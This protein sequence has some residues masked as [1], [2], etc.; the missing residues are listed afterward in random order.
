MNLTCT[1]DRCE[2]PVAFVLSGLCR[3]HHEPTDHIGNCEVCE[4]QLIKLAGARGPA[5]KRCDRHKS[6]KKLLCGM[7]NEVN[8]TTHRSKRC[9][10]CVNAGRTG[11]IR[12]LC[13]EEDCKTTQHAKGY[14]KSHYMKYC[15]TQDHSKVVRSTRR[16]ECKGCKAVFDC[17]SK[18]AR[19][20]CTHDC[21]MKH[22]QKWNLGSALPRKSATRKV[23]KARACEWCGKGFESTNRRRFCSKDCQYIW[24]RESEVANRNGR[25]LNVAI[26][27][28]DYDTILIEIAKRVRRTQSGCWE[29]PVQDKTGY[30]RHIGLALHRVVL[31]AKHRAPLGTQAA[32]HKC[33]NTGCVNPDHL[34][35]VSHAENTAEML[36]RAAFVQRIDE[37]EQAL[38]EISPNHPILNRVPVAKAS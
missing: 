19:Q 34:Q 32:H 30:P 26:Q 14:C 2:R 4:V 18:N 13:T 24:S 25:T 22:R 10:K 29:W 3:I 15:V 35:P 28:H 8:W 27:D 21:A 20:Y 5:P 31:E 33:A 38:T 37:L 23:L 7:C 36:Q 1:V 16:V 9:K 6:W 11:I 17:S 12:A